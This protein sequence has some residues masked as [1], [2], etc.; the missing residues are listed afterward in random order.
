MT[1]FALVALATMAF[2]TV[3][4]AAD[5]FPVTITTALG[6]AVIPAKPK[7]VVTWGWSAQDVVLDLGMVPVG[8][9]FF[10]YGGGDDGVLPWTAEAIA[11]LGVDMPVVLPDSA[12]PPI[13][14]IAALQPDVIIAP[15]SGLTQEEFDL[16]SNIAPV[17][18]Y[19]ETPWFASWQQVVELTGKALGLSA[20]A[21]ALEQQT[22]AFMQAEADKYPAIQGTVF[23]NVINRNDGSVAVRMEEDPRVRLLVD[24]GMQAAP[25]TPG[26]LMV[27]T[28]TSYTLSYETFDQIA[29]DML[30]TFFDNQQSADDFFDLSYIKLA[31]LVQK[32]AVAAIVGEDVIMAV[33]G[34]I[35]PLS[36]RWAFAD[37][38]KTVGETAA[39][40]K[41]D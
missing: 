39:V 26:G 16:L 38:I 37:F 4:H 23:A 15:Y 24:L 28:G 34:A 19:P 17:V 33:G 40:A 30:V 21:E 12:E 11:R 32:H 35:T 18:G 7:R 6:D 14:A 36:L 31:P 13:E 29:A 9:P 27:S 1:K 10:R 20:E 25:M 2:A 3:A 8:M 5:S 41:A 22:Q